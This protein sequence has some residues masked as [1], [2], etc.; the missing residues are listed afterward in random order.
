[1]RSKNQT[2][3]LALAGLMAALV[4]VA[5]QFFKVEVP[6]AGDRTMIGFANV[7]CILSGLLLGPVYGGLAAG[8]GSGLFDL[9]GGWASSAPVTLV[10]KFAMAW[11]CGL[12]AWGGDKRGRKLSR[13]IV[14]AITG[15]L[16][17]CVLYLS[18]SALKEILLGSAAQSVQIIMLTKLGATF[19][20]A[21]AADVI[22]V[23][24][25]FAVKKALERSLPAESRRG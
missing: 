19:T 22:A 24:L 8:I 25:Y 15:S 5:T 20:N 23:P 18:Y 21:V 11:I 1:M 4:F 12:I 10:T 16:S 17:Y 7:F 13:V 2:V 14:G 6:V 9:V 3:N